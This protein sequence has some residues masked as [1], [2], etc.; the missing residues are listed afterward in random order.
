MTNLEKERP[1]QKPEIQLE[2]PNINTYKFI[3]SK[4]DIKTPRLKK[5][6]L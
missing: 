4:F 1:M 5:L 6:A 3:A 2:L